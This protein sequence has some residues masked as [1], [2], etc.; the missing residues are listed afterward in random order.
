MDRILGCAGLLLFVVVI[1]LMWRAVSSRIT[2]RMIT[3]ICVL[4]AVGAIALITGLVM[5]GTAIQRAQA[6]KA[7][8][9]HV[10]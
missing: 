7:E 10:P 5:E 6:E 3:A 2:G 4:G 8:A 1:F 9:C